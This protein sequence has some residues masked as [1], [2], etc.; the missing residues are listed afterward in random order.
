MSSP[1]DEKLRKLAAEV[2]KELEMGSFIREGVYCHLAG[3]S[4]ET[5]FEAR[6]LKLV[7][8]DAVGMSTAPEVVV[9]KHCGMTVLGEIDAWLSPCT[10]FFPFPFFAAFLS[11]LFSLFFSPPLSFHFML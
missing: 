10:L 2:A 11:L 9:A 1:Y 4:Y 3:P 5:P 6:F 8:C 7:G